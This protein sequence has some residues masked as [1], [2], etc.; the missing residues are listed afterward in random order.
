MIFG[1]NIGIIIIGWM[2]VLFGFKFKIGFVVFFVIFMGVLFILFGCGIW[3]LVGLVFVGFGLI[4]IGIEMLIVGL[5]VLKGVVILDS[6][7]F[8]MFFGC[9]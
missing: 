4:F 7:L 5:L 9:L 6:F 2:V 1:V 8:D 3:K